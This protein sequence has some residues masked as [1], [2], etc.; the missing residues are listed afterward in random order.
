[1]LECW[2]EILDPK[3]AGSTPRYDIRPPPKEEYELRV[4]VWGTRDC[5]FKDALEGCNDLFL[6]GTLGPK[7]LE[8]D[9]HWRCRAK[10]SFNWRWKFPVTLPLDVDDDYGGDILKLQLFD[11]DIVGSNELIGEH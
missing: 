4:I 9:T 10:G 7:T 3:V 8:T 6:K 1:M 2:V 5:V 11:R